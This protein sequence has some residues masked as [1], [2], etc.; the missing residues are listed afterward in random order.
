MNEREQREFE[1]AVDS[2]LRRHEADRRAA[3]VR[4]G[5]DP[6]GDVRERIRST[7]QRG[8]SQPPPKEFEP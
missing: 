7:Q 3:T 4:L 6:L 1:R 8:L 5:E 2:G